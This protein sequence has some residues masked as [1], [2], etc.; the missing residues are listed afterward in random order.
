MDPTQLSDFKFKSL[1]EDL[2]SLWTSAYNIKNISKQRADDLPKVG[3]SSAS[4]CSIESSRLFLFL[5]ALR[6]ALDALKVSVTLSD[7]CFATL[8][9]C[10]SNNHLAVLLDVIYWNSAVQPQRNLNQN[11]TQ[12]DIR[13]QAT[14][15]HIY[16]S[17]LWQHHWDPLTLL[18]T[19]HRQ[20]QA[21]A[22]LNVLVE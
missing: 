2:C 8:L 9:Y 10:K 18:P 14:H 21:V 22:P 5:P 3:S 7:S 16:I 19:Q 20:Q 6:A 1:E 13:Q 4:N 11:H 15:D 12:K 17:Y